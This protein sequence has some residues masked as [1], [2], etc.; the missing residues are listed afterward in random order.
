MEIWFKTDKQAVRLPV[1]PQEVH[2][3][4]SNKQMQLIFLK[5]V[6]LMYLVEI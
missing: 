3:N 1:L 6:I 2:V 5:K 4:N